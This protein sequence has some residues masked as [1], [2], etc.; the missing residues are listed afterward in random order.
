MMLALLLACALSGCLGDSPS[1]SQTGAGGGSG[2]GSAGG[3]SGGGGSDGGGSGGGSSGSNG[4]T[5]DP[6]SCNTPST[7][8]KVDENKTFEGNAHRHDDWGEDTEKVIFEDPVTA[9]STTAAATYVN[10]KGAV[11]LQGTG[12]VDFFLDWVDPKD[13]VLPSTRTL[14]WDMP[15]DNR[16]TVAQMYEHTFK[17]GEN[18]TFEINP[19]NADPPHYTRTVWSFRLTSSVD[20]LR[21]TI[22]RGDFCLPIDPPHYEQ[23]GSDTQRT[24]LSSFTTTSATKV[25][26]VSSGG[27]QRVTPPKNSTVPVSTGRME[28]TLSWEQT[29]PRPMTNKLTL[30]YNTA[31]AGSL[32]YN[33]YN[34]YPPVAKE[35]NETARLFEFV[36]GPEDWDSPYVSNSAWGFTARFDNGAADAALS[37]SGQFQGTVRYRV[38]MF[39]IGA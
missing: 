13:A 23:W 34:K 31:T 18:Y 36:V 24:L 2:G 29:A 1:P 11:V 7:K 32:G 39:R 33:D 20:K 28:V 30:V 21:F 25:P 19:E 10:F 17:P 8:V 15:G 4:Q 38:E 12:R 35:I 14:Y 22:Y 5:T 6:E 37:H 26:L 9:G 27:F 16:T 3:G